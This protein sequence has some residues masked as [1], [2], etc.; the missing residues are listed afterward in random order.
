MRCARTAPCYRLFDLADG[1][2]RPGLIRDEDGDGGPVEIEVWRLGAAAFGTFVATVT[3]PLAIGTL[4]LTDGSAVHGFLC[5]AHA[6]LDAREAT[7]FGGWR[8]YLT[9]VTGR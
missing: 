9:A 6:V 3:A 5:E 4:E 8:E 7:R 2:G 1:T